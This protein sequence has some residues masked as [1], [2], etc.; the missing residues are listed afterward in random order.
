MDSKKKQLQTD[1]HS[2]THSMMKC[3]ENYAIATIRQ[4]CYGQAWTVS[5]IF[6]SICDG[7]MQQ[8]NFNRFIHNEHTQLAEP[9][10]I[11]ARVDTQLNQFICYVLC[12]SKE[13]NQSF[14]SDAMS[15]GWRIRSK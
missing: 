15:M 13:Y 4:R 9:I 14:G 1:H 8:A 2:N 3:T 7:R 5:K 11:G 6:V 12:L 10:E